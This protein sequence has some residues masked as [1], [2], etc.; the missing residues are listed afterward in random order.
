MSQGM[1]ADSVKIGSDT[2]NLLLRHTLI[3]ANDCRNV[4]R[5]FAGQQEA[6]RKAEPQQALGFEQ[7]RP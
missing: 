7:E 3:N 5:A 2:A 1:F 6:V 4:G